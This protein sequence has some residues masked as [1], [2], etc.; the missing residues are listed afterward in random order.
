MALADDLRRFLDGR[1]TDGQRKGIWTRRKLLVAGA[2]G[3]TAVAGA[4]W[5]LRRNRPWLVGIIQSQT[6]VMGKGGR[7][8]ILANL[9]AIDALNA[10]GGVLGRKIEP[11]VADGESDEDVFARE[12][13]RMISGLGAQ[14]IFA[15]VI[16]SHCHAIEPV[17]RELG[18]LLFYPAESEGLAPTPNVVRL[19]AFPNQ[20]VLPAVAWARDSLGKR[21]VFL[22]G[23]DSIYPRTVG[24][25]IGDAAADLAVELVGEAYIPSSDMLGAVV[26]AVRRIEDE[27]PDLILSTIYGK[28]N[29]AF[30]HHLRSVARF[31]AGSLPCISFCLSE[32]ELRNVRQEMVGDYVCGYYLDCRIPSANDRVA[33]QMRGDDETDGSLS[34]ISD[35]T[36]SSYVAVHLWAKAVGLAGSA[37]DLGALSGTLGKV[38]FAGPCGLVRVESAGLS[39]RKHARV[40][41]VRSDHTIEEV[42]SSPEAISPIA[43]PNTRSSAQ[44]DAFAEELRMSWN[45]H[46]SNQGSSPAGPN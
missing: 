26:D 25:I 44:W 10:A 36:A 6:G 7:A 4:L 30:I 11:I 28:A 5:G 38:D 13:R 3:A 45:G 33:D 35:A 2:V 22:V 12:A 19:G 31:A 17:A 15:G 46:W 40:C 32:Q 20:N 16:S 18:R 14:A 1:Q 29:W 24:A 37:D 39:T 41:S 42:W 9:A 23:S 21:R 43:Y 27:K 34:V 8:A